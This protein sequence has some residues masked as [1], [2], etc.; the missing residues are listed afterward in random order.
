MS[1]KVILCCVLHRQGVKELELVKGVSSLNTGL[2][3]GGEL[4]YNMLEVYNKTCK[5]FSIH[6]HNLVHRIF[7]L[8]VLL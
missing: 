2:G 4:V 5:Q 3:G 6:E 8:H 1:C 7:Q